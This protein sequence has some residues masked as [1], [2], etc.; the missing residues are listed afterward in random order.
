MGVKLYGRPIVPC[1]LMYTEHLHITLE[2][3]ISVYRDLEEE[4]DG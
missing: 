1:I 4:Q 3:S 2:L